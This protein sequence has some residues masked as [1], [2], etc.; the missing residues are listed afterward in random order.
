M[1]RSSWTRRQVLKGAGVALSLP[2]LETFAPRTAR[3]QADAA[4][5]R[6]IMLYFPNGSA[7]Y[8]N[9]VGA[10]G[11]G[12]AWALSPILAPLQAVKKWVTVVKNV[13]YQAALQMPN[14][15]HSQLGAAI[16]TCAVPAADPNV[17]KA[18]TSVDQVIAT[19][20]GTVTPFASMQVGLSTLDSYP[21][22]RHPSYSRSVSWS[23]PTTPLYKVV[24]PQAVFDRLMDP[25][26]KAAGAA[27]DPLA[28]RRRLLKKSALDFVLDQSKTLQ[29]KLSKSDAGR[30]E[31]FQS[32]VRNLETRVLDT[33]VKVT[34]G[35]QLS[36]RPPM[37]YG[38]GNIP[39][40]YNR[41]THA[42]VMIDL[43]VMALQCDVTRVVSFMLDDARSDF[44][45]IFLKARKFTDAG[46]TE[47]TTSVTNGNIGEG[48]A[49]FHGLQ[50]AGDKNDG[51]ASINYWLTEKA[52]S[53]TSKLEASAEGA[54]G[55]VLDNTTI[56]FGSGM[57]GGNHQGIDVPLAL[58]GGHG[59]VLK[60]DAYLPLQAP[61][62]QNI[63]LTIMQQVFGVTM[64]SFAGSTGMVSELMA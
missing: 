27:P 62:M 9:P 14:P 1:K 17:A 26:G 47:Q 40:T 59:G 7:E 54:A 57:H 33:S 42:D 5:R 20:L 37:A 13:T 53:L 21:D 31:Q 4:R 48:L 52:A 15:S 35:C 46:S 29:T 64:P 11:T 23:S 49:G 12:T 28:E 38:V 60:K 41:N 61:L 24:N 45:Y 3:A 19:S 10:G 58:I 32:T 36:A 44:P 50:H 8:W 55:S 51:F 63:H 25:V 39:P 34:Q 56:H 43:V 2:W 18:G 6:Y 16:A 30:L 22:G